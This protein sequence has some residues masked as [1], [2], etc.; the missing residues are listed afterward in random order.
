MTAHELQAELAAINLEIM[1][2]KTALR[3]IKA[4]STEYFATR[5]AEALKRVDEVLKASESALNTALKHIEELTAIRNSVSDVVAELSEYDKDIQE[6][7]RVHEKRVEAHESILKAK[8][9]EVKLQEAQAKAQQSVIKSEWG[10]INAQKAQIAL[11]SAE[12][13]DKRERLKAAMQEYDKRKAR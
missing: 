6:A 12:I 5:E 4:E 13:A 7:R 3:D 8:L 2:A 10:K 11:D 9:A 1:K